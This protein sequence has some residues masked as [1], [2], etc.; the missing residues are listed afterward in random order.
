MMTNSDISLQSSNGYPIFG[1][2]PQTEVP[3]LGSGGIRLKFNHSPW[4]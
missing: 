4:S 2:G 1:A 3:H